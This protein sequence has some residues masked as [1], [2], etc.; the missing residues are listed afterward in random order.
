MEM[1][2]EKLYS[3]GLGEFHRSERTICLRG[4]RSK[5]LKLSW[6]SAVPIVLAVGCGFILW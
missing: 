6:L 1:R 4:R 5:V 2:W 3:D